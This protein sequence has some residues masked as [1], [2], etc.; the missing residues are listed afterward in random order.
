MSL[1]NHE[2][3]ITMLSSSLLL[4]CFE[5]KILV[6]LLAPC[7]LVE[8]SKWS[9]VSFPFAPKF[10][11]QDKPLMKCICIWIMSTPEPIPGLFQ[12]LFMC[13][14]ST[15]SVCSSG[16][17]LYRKNDFQFSWVRIK[18]ARRKPSLYEYEMSVKETASVTH[19]S[20]EIRIGP[21]IRVQRGSF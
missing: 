17:A 14:V 15:C 10:G 12:K 19:S 16:E 3:S 20:K 18:P 9:V 4:H 5:E 13:D 8:K 11:M 7:L 21:E 6:L 2:L 1:C